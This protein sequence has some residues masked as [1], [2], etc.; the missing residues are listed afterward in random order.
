MHLRWGLQKK[1]YIDIEIVLKS[2]LDEKPKLHPL[3]SL[4]DHH[5]AD[6]SLGSE[7]SQLLI[8][9]FLKLPAKEKNQMVR[10]SPQKV[11]YIL[12]ALPR[13]PA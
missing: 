1:N 13:A 5:G 2:L 6:G 4:C 12:E 3:P 9:Q 7:Q 10:N 8:F 11:T